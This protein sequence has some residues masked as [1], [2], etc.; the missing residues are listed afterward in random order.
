M[1]HWLTALALAAALAD[2]PADYVAQRKEA[3]ALVKSGRHAD[4]LAAFTRML[5]IAQSDLQKSDA[6]QQGLLCA[7]NLKQFDE[8]RE[9]AEQIP[10]PPL[11]K[12]CQMQV[13][14]SERKWLEIVERFR[15]EEIER[16]PESVK[17][18]AYFVRG[19]AFLIAKDGPAAE[20]DFQQAARFLTDHNSLGLCLNHLG[21]TYATLLNDDRRAIDA[22]RQTYL[23]G[24]IYKHCQAAISIAR[25]LGRRLEHAA[26]IEEL[27][28][29]DLDQVTAPYWRAAMLA[30]MGRA[31]AEADRAL[32]AIARFEEALRLQDIPDSVRLECE[33]ALEA[34][35]ARGK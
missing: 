35:R 19:Q 3:V 29:I 2:T 14:S 5:D 11:S 9:M 24:N 13:L 6:L 18:E 27:S 23:T 26:A 10:L 28:K 31:L 22:Y 20:R 8:A 16:W 15:A 34:L 17:G 21:D 33:R 30:A 25:L 4:A 12:T 32:D 1:P 7:I